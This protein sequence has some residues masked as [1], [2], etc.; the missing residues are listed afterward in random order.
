MLKLLLNESFRRYLI[1]RDIRLE[2]FV[3]ILSIEYFMILLM[4]TVSVHVDSHIKSW[5]PKSIQLNHRIHRR[6]RCLFAIHNSEP[7]SNK[8]HWWT[9][10]L[11]VFRCLYKRKLV[12]TR[13]VSI[14]LNVY[15]LC[16]LCTMQLIVC[17][18][19]CFKWVSWRCGIVYF[20]HSVSLDDI[21]PLNFPWNS[22][23]MVPL[24]SFISQENGEENVERK[25][26]KKAKLQME[27][28]NFGSRFVPRMDMNCCSLFLSSSSSPSPLLLDKGGE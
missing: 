25:A 6:I 22:P 3:S 28:R 18:F 20:L 14:F 21:F 27:V 5:T 23:F 15:V 7:A 13:C 10:S 17:R 8:L 9:R 4:F 12:W 26:G 2:N 1:L 19:I 24:R 11:Y 16:V